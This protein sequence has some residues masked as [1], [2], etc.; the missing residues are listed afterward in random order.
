MDKNELWKL[1]H[2]KDKE[3]EKAKGKRTLVTILG[4]AIFYFVVLY[5]LWKPT[6]IKG[7]GE[8]LIAALFFG[9]LHFLVNAAIFSH[10]CNK[11]RDESEVLKQIKKKI[12][13]AE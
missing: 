9:G 10:L 7:I 3:F 12:E 13:E 5:W 1:Y 2:E 4:F 6:D 8:A 11:G